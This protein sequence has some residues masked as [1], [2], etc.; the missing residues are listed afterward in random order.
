[1]PLFIAIGFMRASTPTWVYL[2]LFILGCIILLYHG[3]K[4]VYRYMRGSSYTWVNAIHVLIVA[5]LLLYVGAKQ[6]DTP[7]AGYELLLMTAFA[8]FG[9]HVYS[10]VSQIQT[11]DVSLTT[12]RSSDKAL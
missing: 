3:Y 10:M 11:Y 9:Y 1:M 2:T 8:A 6:K 4:F 5:P 12:T 7:R